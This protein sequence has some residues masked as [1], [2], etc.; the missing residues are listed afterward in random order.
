MEKSQEKLINLMVS[1]V[2]SKHNVIKQD[3]LP[4]EEKIKLQEIVEQLKEDVENFV[5]T[6]KKTVTEQNAQRPSDDTIKPTSHES[7]PASSNKMNV[8]VA[9]NDANAKKIFLPK[10]NK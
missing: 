3:E 2:L 6:H 1:N 8:K 7:A 10:R 4:E 9:P 5:E